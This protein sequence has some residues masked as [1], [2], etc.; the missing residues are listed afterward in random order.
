[1]KKTMNFQDF[2]AEILQNAKGEQIKIDLIKNLANSKNFQELCKIITNN[3]T[4][5]FDDKII[6]GELLEA[7][8]N[9]ELNQWDIAVNKNVEN[10][11]LYAYGDATVEA[12]GHSK[13]FAYGGVV[14]KAFE[15]SIVEAHET[16]KIFAYGN[17]FVEAFN[18]SIV[19]A[20]DTTNIYAYDSSTIYYSGFSNFF[21]FGN[22]KVIRR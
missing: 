18:S 16:S 9:E 10:G 2:K 17:S 15:T 6:T 4:S 19:F 14:V 3:F 5:F 7:V 12:R 20:Y 8:G 21:A 1:M 13:V 22:A 11:C